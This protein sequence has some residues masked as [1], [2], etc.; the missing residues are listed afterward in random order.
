MG[1]IT[2]GQPIDGVSIIPLKQIKDER[3]M[4]MHMLRA[5][6][7]HFKQF[8]EIYFSIVNPGVIKGWKKHK[9]MNQNFA[10]PVGEIKIVIYDDRDNSSTKENIQTIEVGFNKY[11]LIQIPPLVWY[12]FKGISS[13]PAMIANCSSIPHSPDETINLPLTT[14]KIPYQWI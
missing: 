8:G 12:G 4:V 14:N 5:D 10:V 2:S 6:Q 1:A 7:E 11:S 13:E 3:G 9:L